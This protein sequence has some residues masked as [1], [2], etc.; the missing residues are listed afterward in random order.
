MKNFCQCND[1]FNLQGKLDFGYTKCKRKV[2]IEKNRKL[3]RIDT[4]IN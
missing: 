3:P 1:G 2:S 4:P